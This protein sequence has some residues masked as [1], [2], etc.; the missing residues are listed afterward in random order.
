MT[1]PQ[2]HPFL[3]DEWIEAARAIRAA[4][5]DEAPTIEA[6]LRINIV[7]LDVPFR[8]GE[9]RAFLDTSSGATQ[10]ELGELDAAEVTVTTDYV[11]AQAIF[12][13]QDP[14]VAMQSFMEGRVKVQ[15]DMMKLMMLQTT[16]N[17][18]DERAQV[19]A[20]KIAAITVRSDDGAAG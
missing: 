19:V 5:A 20:E 2:A 15:G 1:T 13:D 11:T 6:E 7:V 4:H 17:P 3:S 12:V 18:D 16:V 10:L 9:L 14:A 8:D